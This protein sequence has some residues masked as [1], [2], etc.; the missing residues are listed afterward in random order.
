METPQLRTLEMIPFRER[1]GERILLRD[2]EGIQEEQMVI[3]APL[4]YILL[5]MD[6]TRTLRD[7]QAEYMK[8]FGELLTTEELEGIVN[9]LDRRYLLVSERY[10]RCRRDLEEEYK[11]QPVRPPS[12]AGKSYPATREELIAY[13]EETFP[14]L[15]GEGRVAPDIRGILAPHIDYVRGK[16]VYERVYGQ[17]RGREVSLVVLIGTSH[18]P[19]SRPWAISLKDFSTPLGRLR[20]PTPL[21]KII[22]RS[23][24]NY[25]L[26][27]WSHRQEHSLEL[28]LPLLQYVLGREFDILPIL[29][30]SMD[31][32]IAGE[33]LID[34]PELE[35]LIEGLMDCLR[36]YAEP[37]T[38]VS[39]ADLAHIGF[40]FGDL[41]PLTPE[42]LE[43]SK[44]RDEML[45]AKIRDGDAHGFWEVVKEEGDCRRVCGLAPIY[46]QL[47]LLSDCRC[48][49][50]SYNQ[51]TDGMSSVS[52]A[53]GIFYPRGTE[54]RPGDN[55]LEGKDGNH[56]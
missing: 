7:I 2:P 4:A 18:K 22:R 52:F 30:N 39:G 9:E 17:M 6:G 10:E 46:F 34:E 55:H 48:E 45:L 12:Q 49:I 28:Q 24:L 11:R 14:G 43:R 54:G 32:Y 33:R 23:S 50:L 41:E 8:A 53:G 56:G 25:Y 44:R 13:L 37:F 1:E 27:D 26:D 5:L 42:M 19:L 3:S 36:Q 38:I 21:A 31:A 47:R 29:T 16:E 35:G 40:Q 51:W 20:V 15:K